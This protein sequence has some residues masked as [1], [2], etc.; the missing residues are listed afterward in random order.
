MKSTLLALAILLSL[1]GVLYWRLGRISTEKETLKRRREELGAQVDAFRETGERRRQMET[2]L[3]TASASMGKVERPLDI[4]ELRDL[5]IGA[6]RGLAIDRMS[7]DF[8]PAPDARGTSEGGRV[9]ANLEG[10]FDALYAY[11]D[12]VERLRMP[13]A[14]EAFSLR[15]EGSG[16]VLLAIEWNGLWRLANGTLEDLSRDDLARLEIWLATEGTPPPGR[17]LFSEGVAP[18]EPASERLAHARFPAPEPLLPPPPAGKEPAAL[19]PR[20]MGFVIA[21]PELETDVD[22]RVLAA[23]RFE[24]VLTLAGVGDSVGGYRIEEIDARESVLLVHQETGER[25]K[26]FLE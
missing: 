10:S 6:E 22:R 23:L 12:R 8:R 16:R 25:L 17:N 3:R 9:S 26:L 19:A 13:L 14:P 7:L 5:L 18:A 15:A 2:L 4:A 1:D 21:R 24:G 11:L 20:L